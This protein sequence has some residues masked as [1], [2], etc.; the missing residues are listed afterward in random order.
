MTECYIK[1]VEMYYKHELES[2][3]SVMKGD[4]NAHVN[5]KGVHYKWVGLVDDYAKLITHKLVFNVS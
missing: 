2:M 1:S 4:T 5:P 3:S